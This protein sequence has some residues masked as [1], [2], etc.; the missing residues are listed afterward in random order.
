MIVIKV[1][2]KK[3]KATK[4]TQNCYFIKN[5][6]FKTYRTTGTVFILINKQGVNYNRIIRLQGGWAL[7]SDHFFNIHIV[8]M[9]MGF[10]F[11]SKGLC[12]YWNK[13]GISLINFSIKH[14]AT[15]YVQMCHILSRTFNSGIFITPNH[16]MK[17][18]FRF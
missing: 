14:D 10:I 1:V 7:I 5:M 13:Y 9:I 6:Y 4:D 12:V 3:L 11:K 15:D 2:F 16:A 8:Y 18:N 17:I